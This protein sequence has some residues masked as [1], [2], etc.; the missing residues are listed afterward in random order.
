MIRANQLRMAYL[1]D[2]RTTLTDL[3]EA[4][5]RGR[6]G[7]PGG[8]RPDDFSIRDL[9]AALITD[10]GGE[11]IG[12][13]GLEA[14]CRG[15]LLEADGALTTSAFAAVTG[16]VLNAAVREGYA[17]PE[18]IL[19]QMIPAIDGR[20]REARITGVS[21]PLAEGKALTVAEGE[22]YP[23]VGMYDEYVKT[24]ATTKRGAVVRITKEAVLQDETGQI[25]EQAR[26][27]GELIGL[28]KEIA[29]TDYV[30]GA[31]ANCVIE[32]RV[33]DSAETTSNLYLTSGRWINQQTNP[34]TDWT[35]IDAAE[36]LFLGITMPG[37]GTPPILT[38]RVVLTPP[39][40]RSVAARTLSAT[41]TRSGSS[42]VV[43][44]ANPLS[45]LGLRHIA[46]S[47]IYSR[48]VAAGAAAAT[49]AGT[50]FYGDLTSAFRYY[51]NWDLQVEEDR[52]GALAFSHDVLAQFKAS[53]RGTPVVIEPRLFSKQTPS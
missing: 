43:V 4:L 11:P 19:S 35:D 18:F 22:E 30:I 1:A 26:R 14:L 46:S 51:R 7:R 40:L 48:L 32:K 47:L 27:V 8:L 2:P 42:N 50:W 17:L 13:G 49:A 24:P 41:E 34:L 39:Q 36:D 16:Q 38:G 6:A 10:R 53:E 25:L 23:A 21:L 37:S 45:G 52:S 15:R 12:L 3:S 29:L 44:A 28:Q 33:G 9:A 31:V 5:D 20:A